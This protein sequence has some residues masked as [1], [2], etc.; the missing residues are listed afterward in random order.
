MASVTC[1]GTIGAIRWQR[2]ERA[3]IAG[4]YDRRQD[5]RAIREASLDLRAVQ[6]AAAVCGIVVP[7]VMGFDAPIFYMLGLVAGLPILFA[8]GAGVYEVHRTIRTRSE[9]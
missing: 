9:G 2:M 8:I 1:V 4:R 3:R 7:I 6:I 5:Q